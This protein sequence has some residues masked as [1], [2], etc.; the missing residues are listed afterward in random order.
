LIKNNN[1]IL[2]LSEQNLVDC[3]VNNFGCNG[4]YIEY[5][6]DYIKGGIMSEAAYPV[7][8]NYIIILFEFIL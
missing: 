6:F 2:D 5:A 1:Q 8:I 4:G 3:N 7:N